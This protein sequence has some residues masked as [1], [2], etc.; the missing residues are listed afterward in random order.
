M[1]VVILLYNGMTALDAIGPYE[2]FVSVEGA[3]VKLVAKNKGL[4]KL[5]SKMGYLHADFS[6]SEVNS[7]DILVVPGSRPPNYKSPI[8]DKD[9]MNW[10]RQIHET[11]NWTT[12]VCTGSL[13]LGAAG[14]LNGLNATSHWSCLD[15]LHSYGA[16]STNERVVCQGKIITSAGVSSGID[17]ALQLVAWESGED[18]SKY[19]QLILEY[20]PMPPFDWGSPEKVPA[21]LIEQ[22]KEM[23][24]EVKKQEPEI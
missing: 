3:E 18:I 10:I 23:I 22:L 9:I 17:M 11:T 15:L 19:V 12:S 20:D 14:L 13:I 16:I 8:N 1:K 21:P 24:Q 2:V 4:I 7:A 6:I 5:D